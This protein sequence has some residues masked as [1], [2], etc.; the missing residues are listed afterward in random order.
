LLKPQD[1]LLL[2]KYW[3]MRRSGLHLSLRDLQESIG[4]SASEA[5]KGAKRLLA[6]KLLVERDKGLFAEQGALL[7]WLSYGVR[8]AYPVEKSGF[9]RGMPTAWNCNLVISEMLPPSPPIVWEQARGSAEGVYIKPIYSS[10]LLAASKDEQLYLVLA[11][12]DAIRMGKPRELSIART[13]LERL[14]KET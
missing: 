6:A 4:I 5:S 12:V 14:V 8:Y 2:L 11:L 1:T 3:S 13:L 7:E 10:V 9:G